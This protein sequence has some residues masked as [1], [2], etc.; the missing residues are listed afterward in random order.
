MCNIQRQHTQF[1][2]RLNKI[3]SNHNKDFPIA[4]IDDFLYEAS[5]DYVDVFSGNNPQKAL[6]YGFELD[7]MRID[8]LS[9]LVVDIAS[10]DSNPLTP[11]NQVNEYGFIKYE[12]EL[13]TD[14]NPYMHKV[15]FYAIT[16]CG[17]VGIEI[18][19]HDDINIVLTDNYQQPNLDWKR[20]VGVI[21]KSPTSN[22]SS[23]FVY[24][25]KPISGINGQYIKR[26]TKP[27]FGNYD[28]LEALNGV[29]GFP[30]S[31]DAPINMDIPETYCQVVVDIAVQN[32]SGNLKDYNHTNYLQQKQQIN[33]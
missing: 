1:K 33:Y 18:K 26:P 6:L 32:V 20:L 28:T 10:D 2:Q 27:F 11:I 8:M 14:T 31:G 15:R 25:D 30:S 13:G 5:L 24:S 12:F 17:N 29:T 4:F 9:T 23:L 16:D 21:K 22:K 19:Q 7:Q 3:D